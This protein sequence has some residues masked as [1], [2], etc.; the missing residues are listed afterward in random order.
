MIPGVTPLA[1]HDGLARLA[2]G[3]IILKINKYLQLRL[4]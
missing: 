3:R 1:G 4:S 2:I